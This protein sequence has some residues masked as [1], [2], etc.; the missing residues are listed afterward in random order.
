[1]KQQLIMLRITIANSLEFALSGRVPR[2]TQ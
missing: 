2:C 1:M